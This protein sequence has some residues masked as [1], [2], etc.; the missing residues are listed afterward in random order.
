MVFNDHLYFVDIDFMMLL[1]NII[2]WNIYYK[3]YELALTLIRPNKF[4]LDDLRKPEN[5]FTE[6]RYGSI[7]RGYIITAQ[8]QLIP[9]DFQKLIINNYK[10]EVVKELE[11]ADHYPMFS[12]PEELT[13]TLLDIA[14]N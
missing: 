3:D 12:V 4:F 11:K 8:D 10:V 6:E 5:K 13:K 14:L 2:W 1:I 9:K 7:P